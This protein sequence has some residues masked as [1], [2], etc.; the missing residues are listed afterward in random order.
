M[1]HR[2]GKAGSWAWP[3][4][5]WRSGLFRLSPKRVDVL[6]RG[7]GAGANIRRVGCDRGFNGRTE[8]GVALDEFRHARGKAK[9]VLEHKDLAVAG[10]ASTD[11][12]G[13]DFDRGR[14]AAGG[15]VARRARSALA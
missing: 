14:D 13:R 9:H 7:K 1:W 5:P 4:N 15:G 12:D 11:A 10:H 6:R 8:L 3:L 2:Q